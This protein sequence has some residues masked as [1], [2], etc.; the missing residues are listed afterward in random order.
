MSKYELL[1][2]QLLHEGTLDPTDLFQPEDV[3]EE[4]ITRTHD[5]TYWEKLKV[6]GLSPSE[7]RRTGFPYS[8]QLIRR[9]V[10]IMSGTLAATAF[11]LEDGVALNIAG[12]THHAFVDRGEGFCLLND[13]A[14]ASNYLLDNEMAASIL[15]IDLDV[16]QGNGT[17][18]IFEDEPA[19]FTF[20]MHGAKNYPLEKESSDWDIPLPDGTGDGEYLDHLDDALVTLFSRL[21]PDFVFYQCGVDVLANDRLGR[22]N[23]SLQGCRER[24][25]KVLN[26]CRA[27]GVPL[28]A[29]MGGGYSPT[30]AEIVEA[31]ANTFRLARE[32]FD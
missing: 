8:E 2:Q 5:L 25:K 22:L 6:G 11:A 3:S 31:H 29:C 13:Q 15:I 28:V 14:I 27:H 7:I 4:V 30:L 12:G 23:L 9:E 20:S 17:A 1:P 18:Q 10:N 24:D 26:A 32:I 19:V 21:Q 16:H